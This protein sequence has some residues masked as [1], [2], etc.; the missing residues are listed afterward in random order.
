[1]SEAGRITGIGGVFRRARDPDALRAFYAG[2][3]GLP[4]E[5]E[6]GTLR[7]R[8]TDGTEA[9][10]IVGFFDEDTDYFGARDQ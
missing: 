10:S 2:R 4:L 1:M 3:L 6:I 8:E 5:D 9:L 7:W